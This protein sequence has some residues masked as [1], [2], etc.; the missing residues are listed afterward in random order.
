MINKAKELLQNQV[1]KEW[2]EAGY[3][4]TFIGATGLGKSK[5]GI[6]AAGE[7]I[8]N[9]PSQKWLIVVPTEHLRD[10]EWKD[11]FKKWGYEKEMNKGV[12]IQCIQTA[13]KFIGKTYDGLV[14]DEMHKTL[15][16]KHRTIFKN[17]T[18]EKILGLMPSIIQDVEKCNFLELIAP[19]FS[20]LEYDK[21]RE[22]GLIAGVEI[23][24]LSV[25]FTEE[26][27]KEYHRLDQEFKK[28][29]IQCHG[30]FEILKREKVTHLRRKICYN[31]EQ[32]HEALQ[33]IF[34]RYPNEKALIFNEFKA[35]ADIARENIGRQSLVYHTGL[36]KKQRSNALLAFKNNYIEY[37]F[38]VRAL[39]EG[40][41]ISDC[42]LQ[43]VMSGNSTLL[44]NTQRTG[45]SLRL[46][47]DGKIATCFHL[48]VPNTIEE[49][50]V[51]K[52]LSTTQD[53]KWINNIFELEQLSLF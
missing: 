32:K 8:R 40:T 49:R 30:N 48:Y 13:Y 41:N 9:D 26:E 52:R 36:S 50:I 45:R 47:E 20:N 43:V 22:L 44:Q 35:N 51:R 42:S 1:L 17:N 28:I 14:V 10:L 6:V 46:K 2:A 15:S 25:D 24:C 5:I 33:S 29:Y 21:I 31:A 7:G 37:L 11:E 23:Y 19:V 12:E 39:D 27:S 34:N 18:F 4:G 53:V 3:R 38:S 16:Y